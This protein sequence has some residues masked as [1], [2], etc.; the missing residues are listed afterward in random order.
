MSDRLTTEIQMT[1]DAREGVVLVH[2]LRRTHRSMRKI[3]RACQGAGFATLNIDYPSSK[4][5]IE[6]HAMQI[7]AAIITFA[8]RFERVH[9]VGFSMG[10]LVVREFL[11]HYRPS[12][13]GR[14]VMIAPP[15]RGSHIA[16]LLTT[17]KHLSRIAP[18]WWGPALYE[19]TTAQQQARVHAE[20][21]YPLGVIAGV[22]GKFGPWGRLFGNLSNDGLVALDSTRIDGMSGHIMLPLPHN[23]LIRD[24]ASIR[25]V[26]SFLTK[27][28]L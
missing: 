19:L 12:N 13:L 18:K 8:T 14:V 11:A 10:A 20:V 27:G 22:T 7:A 2:G 16:D 24:R 6:D 3:A 9:L 25:A 4:G 1:D 5:G 26:V 21:D 28:S 23:A 17:Q 15:A